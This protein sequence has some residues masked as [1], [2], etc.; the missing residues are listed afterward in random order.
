MIS[1]VFPGLRCV[2]GAEGLVVPKKPAKPKRLRATASPKPPKSRLKTA[3]AMVPLEPTTQP[4]PRAEILPPANKP[5]VHDDGFGD[6][7]F[8]EALHSQ[9]ELVSY[10]DTEDIPSDY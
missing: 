4:A 7:M 1:L 9:G 2:H 8:I 10:F 5:S 3:I 6:Q